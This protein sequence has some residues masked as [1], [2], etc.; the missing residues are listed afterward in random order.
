MKPRKKNSIKIVLV[1]DHPIVLT[2]LRNALSAHDRFEIVGEATTGQEA[3]R[4]AGETK[5]HVVVMDISL[6]VMNGLEATKH[7]R[8]TLPGTQVL[9][10]TMHENKEYVLEIIKSGAQGYLL[11][12]SSPADLV[13]AIETVHHG[14][15]FFSPSISQMLVNELRHP[16]RLARRQA[17]PLLTDRENDVLELVAQ[18]FTNKEIASKLQVSIRTVQ[19][20]RDAI[21]KKLNLFTV[22]E[23]TAFALREGIIETH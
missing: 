17:L 1:D 9:V 4:V 5:P 21:M 2:G 18:G 12:D 23:L 3:I 22:A 13:T 6:P 15:S 14:G 20:H 11:K 10:L 8:K 7:I 19:T 16:N